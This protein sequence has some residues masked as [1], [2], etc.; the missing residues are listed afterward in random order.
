MAATSPTR[1]L[2]TGPVAKTLLLFALPTL[3]GNILQSLNSTISSIYLGKLLGENALAATT[4]AVMVWFLVFSTIFG[5]AMASTILIGQAKGRGD[6][7]EVRRTI[8][9]ATGIFIS[10]GISISILGY[11]FTPQ[12]L[13]LLATPEAALGNAIT[14]LRM[15]FVGM[16]FVFLAVLLQSALRGLGDA[17]TPLYSTILNVVLCILLNPLFI[18]GFG[19][20]P[21]LGIG[22]GALAGV[23]ANIAC[24]IF[25]IARIYAKDVAIRLRGP[26]WHLVK[27]D[28]AHLKPILVIGLPMGLSM[29]IMSS[30]QLVMMGLI[31]RE[32][33]DT[34]AAFGAINQL[35][36]Y[37]QM[38][39]F[40]VASAVSAMAAQN[41]GAEKWDR[42]DR[43]TWAGIGINIT[44]TA[45]L[46]VIITAFATPLLGLFLP[47]DSAAI[48]IGVHIQWIVGWTFILMGISMVITSVV[49]AN[50]VVLAPLLILI[51]GSVIVRLT[52]GFAG[53]P[54]YGAEAIW[55]S[56]PSN[57][58]ATAA[59][60]LLYYQSGHWRAKRLATGP[61]MLPDE[62]A[63]P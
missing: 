24:L 51:F 47:T 2:T 7:A 26:E 23:V 18:L 11:I 40:A 13:R 27:P 19:P 43:I 49:R 53:Q 29:I 31:N 14:Y 1:D 36:S 58:I 12:M 34:V 33:V 38:P 22:G 30:S 28:M 41:I 62:A 45:V 37:V 3:G 5:L 48:P 56:Y 60:A 8:G 52:V 50:G 16:P 54:T 9:A 21:P 44:M 42:I 10:V 46:V 63:F 57:S 61:P 4:V 25:L 59:L 15:T 35:W 20:V 32:G 55:W 17:V 39:A 6:I